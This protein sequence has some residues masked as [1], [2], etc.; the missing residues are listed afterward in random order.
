MSVGDIR[1][2]TGLR[3]VN[4]QVVKVVGR[5]EVNG[6]DAAAP[7]E[8]VAPGSPSKD[9]ISHAVFNSS[10]RPSSSTFLRRHDWQDMLPILYL[11]KLLHICW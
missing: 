6:G 11:S 2:L 7:C 5:V 3:N 4:M 8:N 1:P 9:Y 10:H